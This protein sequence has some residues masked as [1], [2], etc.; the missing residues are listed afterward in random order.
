[1]VTT[2]QPRQGRIDYDQVVKMRKM[3]PE[4]AKAFE[5][6]QW[7]K[8]HKNR[9]KQEIDQAYE[10]YQQ[11]MKNTP[12]MET[13]HSDWLRKTIVDIAGIENYEEFKEIYGNAK[14]QLESLT[15]LEKGLNRSSLQ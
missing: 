4:K 7:D 13:S 11:R 5:K 3:D 2:S 1:M 10:N 6:Q 8:F 15:D 14:N 12:E 9:I